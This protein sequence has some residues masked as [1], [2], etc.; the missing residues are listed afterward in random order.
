[1]DISGFSPPDYGLINSDP[2]VFKQQFQAFV[3]ALAAHQSDAGDLERVNAELSLA[4]EGANRQVQEAQQL[5]QQHR[6]AAE[7]ATAQHGLAVA[8]YRQSRLDGDPTLPPDLIEGQ[9]VEQV[10]AA[11]D[12]ARAVVNYIRDKVLTSGGAGVPGATTTAPP[13]RVSG[14]APGRTPPD[15]SAMTAREKLIFGTAR[16]SA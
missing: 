15:T 12:R 2:L 8:A 11:I 14:G 10:D 13:P 1:M 4:L 9:T 7:A 3:D 6:K 5:A 16:A